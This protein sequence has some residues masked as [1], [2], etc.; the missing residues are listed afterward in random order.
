MALPPSTEIN[1]LTFVVKKKVLYDA[2]RGVI[3]Q[4]IGE[5]T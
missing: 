3:F 4:R 2:F 5:K 1:E